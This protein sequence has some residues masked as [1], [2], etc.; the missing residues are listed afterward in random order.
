MRRLVLNQGD[1]PIELNT[2][3][4]QRVVLNRGVAARPPAVGAFEPEAVETT[5]ESDNWEASEILPGIEIRVRPGLKVGIQPVGT[6]EVPIFLLTPG[7]AVGVQP[8]ASGLVQPVFS[9]LVPVLALLAKPVAK[10]IG[11]ALSKKGRRKHGN[12]NDDDDDADQLRPGDVT[13]ING[14]RY[15][16]AGFDQT[17][18]IL[19]DSDGHRARV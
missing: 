7:Q 18:A 3:S 10:A 5:R 9:G 4:N 15:T 13:E 2:A 14:T 12:V 1:L 19:I 8:T 16:C 17:G 11:K 6:S